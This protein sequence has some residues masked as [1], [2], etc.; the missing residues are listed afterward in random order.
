MRRWRKTTRAEGDTVRLHHRGPTHVPLLKTIARICRPF[1][2]STA[3]A[4]EHCPTG[5]L[6]DHAHHPS[7]VLELISICELAC[8]ETLCAVAMS[9]DELSLGTV[10]AQPPVKAPAARTVA[11]GNL[12]CHSP[13]P[14]DPWTCRRHQ[15][16]I[17]RLS[18]SSRA[19]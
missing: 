4:S 1:R 9:Q 2:S 8:S 5:A 7:T 19:N 11:D 3:R 17:I 15:A 18:A 16:R 6:D 10:Q 12:T 13:Y 14:A